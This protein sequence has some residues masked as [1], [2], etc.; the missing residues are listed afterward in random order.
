M[1]QERFLYQ[2]CSEFRVPFCK[3]FNDM[4]QHIVSRFLLNIEYTISLFS[5]YADLNPYIMN[6]PVVLLALIYVALAA[7]SSAAVAGNGTCTSNS[8]CTE[9]QYCNANKCENKLK[10]GD[11]CKE[12]TQCQ[13]NNCLKEGK[14]GKDCIGASSHVRGVSLHSLL[15]PSMR[16]QVHPLNLIRGNPPVRMLCHQAAGARL[17]ATA[18]HVVEADG[19][20]MYMAEFCADRACTVSMETPLNF[21]GPCGAHIDFMPGVRVT[22]H[23]GVEGGQATA[24]SRAECAARAN[25]RIMWT[26]RTL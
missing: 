17:C 16:M 10:E 25:N 24:V 2:T 18:R 15:H 14:C 19:Q 23:S 9:I 21:K 3:V 5:I 11:S 13:S 6:R 1:P 22:Q 8:N 26:L 4:Q 7:T 12:P 20:L